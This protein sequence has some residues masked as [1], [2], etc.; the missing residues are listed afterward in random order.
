MVKLE[1]SILS[2]GQEEVSDTGTTDPMEQLQAAK[3]RRFWAASAERANHPNYEG[4][5][6]VSQGDGRTTREVE[7]IFWPGLFS[8]TNHGKLTVRFFV[9]K[10]SL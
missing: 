5:L 8:A 9:K 4:T 3:N 7:L 6:E 1:Q 10:V 2:N